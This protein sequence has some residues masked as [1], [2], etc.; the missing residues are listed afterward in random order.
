MREWKKK[1]RAEGLR[2]KMERRMWTLKEER[3]ERR[4]EVR[5]GKIGDGR[6]RRRRETI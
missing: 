5:L 2:K 4:R 6:E 3:K 1:E